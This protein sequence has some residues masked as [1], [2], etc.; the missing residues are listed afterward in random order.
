MKGSIVRA[1]VLFVVSSFLLAG[2]NREAKHDEKAEAPPKAVVE[3]VGGARLFKV[4]HPDEFALVAATE[5]PATSTLNVTGTVAAD[6]SRTIPVISLANGRVV[7]VHARL[8]DLVRK[9]QLLMEVQ[10]TDVSGAFDLYLKAVNDERLANIQLERAKILYDK[11]ALPKS[12][13]EITENS[14][15]DAKTDETAAEQQLRVLGVDPKNP[16]VAVKIYS[17]ATGVII[18]QNVTDAAAAGVGLSGSSTAFT[19]ADLSHVWVIC[20]V[21]EN[22]L[23]TLHLGQV[24]DIHLNAYPDRVIKGTISDIGAVLDPSLRTAKV[25]IQ[26]ENPNMLMRIGMF[27]TAVLHGQRPEMHTIVPATAILHLED[28]DWVYIPAEDSQFRRIEVHAGAILP[29][30]QQEVTAGLQPGQKVVAQALAMQN[31]AAQ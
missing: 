26:V 23:A 19:I 17:P 8:G 13:L 21:Y 3:N 2:C 10:S 15:Q 9:G 5:H 18:S 16:S 12:Q 1:A 31:S 28:R 14:E 25:R 24:A 29:G 6:I 7:A 22:D 20:D 30:N 4:D 27:V 11:G